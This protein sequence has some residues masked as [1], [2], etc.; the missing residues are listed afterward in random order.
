[1]VP[2]HPD[3]VRPGFYQVTGEEASLR[4]VEQCGQEERELSNVFERLLRKLDLFS[5]LRRLEL[6]HSAIVRESKH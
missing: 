5:N 2:L 4:D 3:S 1:M 6:L